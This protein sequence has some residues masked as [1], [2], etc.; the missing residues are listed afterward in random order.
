MNASDWFGMDEGTRRQRIKEAYARYLPQHANGPAEHEY[1]SWMGNSNYEQ[2]IA[3][4]P[5]AKA[6]AAGQTYVRQYDPIGGFDMN[7]LNSNHNTTKYNAARAWQ[8]W[9]QPNDLQ[10][11]TNYY[12]TKYG[13]DAQVTGADKVDYGDGFGSIDNLFGHGAGINRFQWAPT[14]TP[15]PARTGTPAPVP[16][17]PGAPVGSAATPAPVNPA[18]TPGRTGAPGTGDQTFASSLGFTPGTAFQWQRGGQAAQTAFNTVRDAIAQNFGREASADE[19]WNTYLKWE[20]APDA[21]FLQE[22]V[23]NIAQQPEAVAHRN[24]PAAT[25]AATTAPAPDTSQSNY[26]NSASSELFLNEALSRLEQLHQPVDDPFQSIYALYAMQQAMGLSGDPYT[27]GDDAA[28]RARYMEPL[29]Q[30]RDA[31][32]QQTAERMGARGI[33]PSSGLYQ[34]QMNQLDQGYERGVA[35]GSNDLAVRAIDEKQRR[36]QQQL[37]IFNS[38][39]QMSSGQRAENSANGR[40]ALSVAGL[41]P[42]FESDRLNQLLAAS[43]EGAT[44]TSNLAQWLQTMQNQNANQAGQNNQ[45][46]QQSSYAWAQAIVRAMAALGLG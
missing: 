13:A 39:M 21:R 3:N 38:L 5:E 44:S 23:H 2:E 11:F 17:V 9:G 29:T 37:A 16:G 28:L 24:A 1:L 10:G 43:G 12:N 45:N 19:I 30:A 34:D 22:I 32:Q 41:F 6:S 27:A 18:G 26:G 15:T 25:P 33:T 14:N 8:E 4:S 36:N 46:S 7:K 31:A 35:Q 42:Q 20:R 40:E